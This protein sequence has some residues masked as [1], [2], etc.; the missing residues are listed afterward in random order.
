MYPAS[1]GIRGER[2]LRHGDVVAAARHL[3]KRALCSGVP[4]GTVGVVVDI[5]WL[6]DLR[7]E[8][9]L[10]GDWFERRSTAVKVVAPCDVRLVRG[11]AERMSGA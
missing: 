7:V 3:G 4:L 8:F 1:R 10:D 5:D 2:A 11:V 9:V 6:G